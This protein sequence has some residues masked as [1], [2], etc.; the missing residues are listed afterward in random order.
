[1]NNQQTFPHVS[2]PGFE[3]QSHAARISSGIEWFKYA[4]IAFNFR[5]WITFANATKGWLDDSKLIYD[6]LNPGSNRS[7][8]P[9]RTY[10]PPVVY[11]FDENGFRVPWFG[12][13]TNAT[14]FCPRLYTSPPPY[15][16]DGIVQNEDLY[17]KEL[18]KAVSSGATESK[19]AFLFVLQS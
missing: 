5:E 8:D 13:E 6:Q 17:T 19:G 14:P 7:A 2:V 12:D 4:P 18:Y 9:P 1:M 15:Q 10:L 11:R 3:V 16:G